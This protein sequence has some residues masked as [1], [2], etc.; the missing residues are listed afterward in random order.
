MREAVALAILPNIMHLGGMD[1]IEDEITLAFR[2][3]EKFCERIDQ[4]AEKNGPET[5]QI[6]Q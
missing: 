4:D 2:Y 1:L 6:V 5:L 3:A